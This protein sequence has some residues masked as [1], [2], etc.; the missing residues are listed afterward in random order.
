IPN[1]VD[2]GIYAFDETTRRAVRKELGIP[3]DAFVIG[4]VGRFD[5]MKNQAFLVDVLA[6]CGDSVAGRPPYLLFVGDGKLRENVREKAEKEGLPDRVLFAGRCSA[7]RTAAMYQAFDIFALPSY[8]E[9]LPGTAI[10]AQAAG[11]PCLISDRVTKES[12][13]TPQVHFLSIEDAGEWARAAAGA[14]GQADLSLRT[15]V[16]RE[17]RETLMKAGYDAG[18]LAMHMQ[19]KYLSFAK[20]QILLIAPSL[21]QGGLER[22]CVRTARLLAAERADVYQV[23]IA[24][25]DGRDAAYD[26]TGLDV[27]DL[28]L[29]SRKGALGKI[30]NLERRRAALRKLKKR[31]RIDTS[32]SLG[33]TANLAGIGARAGDR[34]ICGIRS[35]QDFDNPEKLRRFA[36]E[37]D[38]IACCSR[39]MEQ[40]FVDRFHPERSCTV[41]NPI[42]TSIGGESDAVPEGKITAFLNTHPQLIMSMG[43]CDRIKGFWHLIKAFAVLRSRESAKGFSSIAEKSGLIIIGAGDFRAYA[44]LAEAL[45]IGGDVLFTGLL[46]DPFPLLKK[47]RL[48]ALTSYH[49]GFP[50]ALVEALALGVPA[51]AADCRTGPAEI[52]TDDADCGVLIP[53]L[54]EKEDLN[55]AH[56]SEEEKELAL[57]MEEVLSDPAR[58]ERMHENAPRRAAAFSDSAYVE[59]LDKMFRMV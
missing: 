58:W 5:E 23:H 2:T 4:H 51:I 3:E 8:Y 45:G 30:L 44:A 32:Y 52:L 1:A 49:E 7:D 47:A 16:S 27:T 31:L 29:P 38:L 28:K 20:K 9:G 10:E 21:R 11:L 35:Y 6:A 33:Q 56:I 48:Y 41:Y 17:A 15:D 36:L 57:R 24:L 42:N 59:A 39:Q 34:I 37:A 46:T 50:N 43:R 53:L 55:P 40:D 12:A 25:F 26:T 14:A 22:V 54:A 18:A 19:E 13:V